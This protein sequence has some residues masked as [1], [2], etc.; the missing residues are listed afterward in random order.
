MGKEPKAPRIDS[1]SRVIHAAPERIYTAL[2]DPAA[3]VT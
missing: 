1:A 3:I 2:V